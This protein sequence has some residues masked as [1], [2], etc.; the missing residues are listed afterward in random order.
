VAGGSY[1]MADAPSMQIKVKNYS[2]AKLRST[3]DWEPE[4][5][6]YEGIRRTVEAQR[7]E[8]VPSYA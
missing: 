2:S 1:E 3:I 7:R 6:I 8:P 5:G 4:V